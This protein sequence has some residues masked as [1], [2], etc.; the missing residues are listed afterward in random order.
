MM[1]NQ[2]ELLN[3]DPW[4]KKLKD[5]NHELYK[6]FILGATNFDSLSKA[7]F[8]YCNSDL[9]E[10]H[11]LKIYA[12]ENSFVN[13][14]KLTIEVLKHEKCPKELIHEI[15]NNK[16]Q[17][18]TLGKF[19]AIRNDLTQDQIS[20]LMEDANDEI[21]QSLAKNPMINDATIEKFAKDQNYWVRRYIAS[22][23]NLNSNLINELIKDE[24]LIVRE[25]I[26][27]YQKLTEEQIEKLIKDENYSVHQ[28]LA[29]NNSL[30]NKYLLKLSNS[31][32]IEVLQAL[33]ERDDLSDEIYLEIIKNPAIVPRAEDTLKLIVA[34]LKKKEISSKILN[35]LT[36][37]LIETKTLIWDY[38]N[39]NQL[40]LKSLLKELL[41]KNSNLSE[42]N[43]AELILLGIKS[44]SSYMNDDDDINSTSKFEEDY[45]KPSSQIF[46]L[47]L[48]IE[49]NKENQ[50]FA[51]KFVN[52][53]SDLGHPLGLL[54]PLT[55]LNSNVKYEI[56]STYS[57][58][59]SH[60]IIHRSLWPEVAKRND[61]RFWIN[62]DEYDGEFYYFTVEGLDSF[63]TSYG[64]G[65]LRI[66]GL[67]YP[68]INDWGDYRDWIEDD[69]E[70]EF[71][72][73]IGV[74]D[75]ENYCETKD[76]SFE[77]E[78]AD[79]ETYNYFLACAI[80]EISNEIEITAK[81]KKLIIESAIESGVFEDNYR[82]QAN[83]NFDN[84]HVY[85]WTKLT[86]D[87][88]KFNVKLMIEGLNSQNSVI[89]QFSDYFLTSIA[90]IP[91]LKYEI[92]TLLQNIGDDSINKALSLRS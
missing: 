11:L 36:R 61:V 5:S 22:R 75:F 10:E 23:S 48:D 74:L 38:K 28:Y 58:W 6:E 21:K 65:E 37:Y 14:K 62:R 43:K 54:H 17:K 72:D 90:L 91:D 33:C 67:D 83:I 44:E 60:E 47:G 18:L 52:I 56:D 13:E 77:D 26:A 82:T 35:S 32:Y 84:C 27:K 29:L 57:E 53:F 80:K 2:A 15:I 24:E 4:L 79:E 3:R 39:L 16:S 55:K 9:K 66:Y 88:Q 30:S 71:E 40:T 69:E 1:N 81:G 12:L 46:R 89:Y 73:A 68:F 70:I 59:V 25:A 64:R 78:V 85:G 49:E 76:L 86:L 7:L 34:I 45:S 42:E 92:K 19:I 87:K 20:S 51:L 31:K 50:I 63:E 41:F 8:I